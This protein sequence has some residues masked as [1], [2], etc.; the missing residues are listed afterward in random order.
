RAPIDKSNLLVA[1]QENFGLR[2]EITEAITSVNAT[3]SKPH[4]YSLNMRAADFGYRPSLT[5]LEGLLMEVKQM[6]SSTM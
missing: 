2:Y 4:Y 3:G 5:S 6:L 1:M